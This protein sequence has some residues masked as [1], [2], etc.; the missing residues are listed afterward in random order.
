MIDDNEIWDE[1][2]RISPEIDPAFRDYCNS[3]IEQCASREWRVATEHDLFVKSD[4][5]GI[6][7]TIDRIY[8]EA[9]YFSI[10]RSV[11]PPVSGIYPRDRIRVVGYALCLSEI[12]GED[13][14]RAIVEYIPGGISRT[15]EIQPRDMRRFLAVKKIMVNIN[16]GKV[17]QKP[18]T[19]RCDTCRYLGRCDPGPTRLSDRF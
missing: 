19:A 18:L 16:A 5:Y 15:C 12:L 9:P 6:C 4:R 8:S 7:G 13:L 3:C 11:K 10:I 2:C 14:N 1:I 17:P